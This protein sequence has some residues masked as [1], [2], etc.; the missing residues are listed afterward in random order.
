MQEF[1]I[2]DPKHRL[3]YRPWRVAEQ[4]GRNWMLALFREQGTERAGPVVLATE[5]EV[6][7]S[8]L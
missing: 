5:S 7:R 3:Y 2:V 1:L 6:E 4:A 8:P